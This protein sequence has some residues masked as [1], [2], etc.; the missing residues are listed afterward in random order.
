M[1]LAATGR[2]SFVPGDVEGGRDSATRLLRA[3][4]AT[5]LDASHATEKQVNEQVERLVEATE[6]GWMGHERRAG[7]H[8]DILFSP[9]IDFGDCREERACPSRV[10]G[11]LGAA[12]QSR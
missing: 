3:R 4:L 8:A 1:R 7:S 2:S 9:H 5:T 12:Q 10:D 11:Q 6:V